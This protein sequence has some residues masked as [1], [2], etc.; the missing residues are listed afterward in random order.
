ML[1]LLELTWYS[2]TQHPV[3]PS[4]IDQ[5]PPEG[6][7]C[8]LSSCCFVALGKPFFL[9][10]LILHFLVLPEDI[11]FCLKKCDKIHFLLR[12]HQS[13]RKKLHFSRFFISHSTFYTT[14]KSINSFSGIYYCRWA[15]PRED[16]VRQGW[17]RLLGTQFS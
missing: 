7:H 16:F 1:S 5:Q 2:K 10:E 13:C 9:R 17:A 3:E 11:A 6:K 15:T 4:Q 14:K 8:L 12:S